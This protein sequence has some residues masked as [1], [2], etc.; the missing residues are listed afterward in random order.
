MK[1]KGRRSGRTFPYG[2]QADDPIRKSEKN[3]H[4][5]ARRLRPGRMTTTT[6]RRKNGRNRS[7]RYGKPFVKHSAKDR[8]GMPEKA[9]VTPIFASAEPRGT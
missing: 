2:T 7:D 9:G 8:P 6:P 4:H 1:R 5:P 3:H